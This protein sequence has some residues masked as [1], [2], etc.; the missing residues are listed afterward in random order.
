M[1]GAGGIAHTQL[2]QLAEPLWHPAAWRALSM[3][4]G[5]QAGAEHE[6]AQTR[7]GELVSSGF[8]NQRA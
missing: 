6:G 1:R 7:L 4:S 8:V 3:G 2:E 5:L